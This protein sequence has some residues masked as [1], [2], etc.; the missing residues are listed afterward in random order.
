MI[1]GGD[2]VNVR[3]QLHTVCLVDKHCIHLVL[4]YQ[5]GDGT[6]CTS[7]YGEQFVDENFTLKHDCPGLLSM[8]C[9]ET[10]VFNTFIIKRHFIFNLFIILF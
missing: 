2:F 3:D 4:F 8:V 7:I 1:Q 10:L 9:H 5:Q 6:G